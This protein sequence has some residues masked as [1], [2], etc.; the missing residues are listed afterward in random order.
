MEFTL[1]QELA[2]MPVYSWIAFGLALVMVAL[3]CVLLVKSRKAPTENKPH[4][5]VPAMQKQSESTRA[6]V[7]GALCIGLSFL[8]SYLKLFSMPQ[9]GSLTPASMLPLALYAYWFG[10]KRGVLA[11]AVYGLLQLVQGAYVIHPVQFALDYVVAYAC[12]GL[13][14]LFPKSLPLGLIVGGICRIVCSVLSGVVFFAEYAGAMNV[15]VYSIGYNFFAM[16]PDVLIC[17]V[18]ALLPPVMHALDRLRPSFLP[19]KA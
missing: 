4:E 5:A 19:Q 17:V 8:L 1:F 2:G 18:I 14:G 13:A 6:L 10:A 9:G 16:G 7:Y 15:W 3:V 12:V 11:G